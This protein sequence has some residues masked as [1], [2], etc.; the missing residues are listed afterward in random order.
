[1]FDDLPKELKTFLKADTELYK[2]FY[3]INYESSG[4]FPLKTLVSNN[5]ITMKE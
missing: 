3:T 2:N 1:M 5:T 4:K